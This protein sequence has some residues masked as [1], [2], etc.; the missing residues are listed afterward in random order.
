MTTQTA[1]ARLRKLLESLPAN[2][3]D[4]GHQFETIA[5]F[6]LLSSS[7]HGAQIDKIWRWSE[8]PG[9]HGTRDT[10]IDRVVRTK[11]G[12]LWAVQV[13]CVAESRAIRKEEVDSFLADS[14][15]GQFSQRLL[16]ATTDRLGVNAQNTIAKQTV[17]PVQFLGREWLEAIDI[18]WPTTYG[19]VLAELAAGSPSTLREKARR[20]PRPHQAEAVAD[21]VATLNANAGVEDRRASLVMA[22]GTGKTITC[23]EVAERM[24]ARSILVLLPNLTLVAQTMREWLKQYRGQ[25]RV[26]AVCGDVTVYGART[27]GRATYAEDPIL[28][29]A[30]HLPG[31]RL[32]DP[33]ALAN[34]LTEQS[35]TPSVVFST[36][37]SAPVV[38]AAQKLAGEHTFDLLVADEAHVLAGR[39]SGA[40]AVGLDNAQIRSR[41]R[42]FAT[43]TPRLV[44]AGD[45]PRVLS[46]DDEDTFGPVAHTLTFGKAIAAGL[47]ADYQVLV[48]GVETGAY[49][50]VHERAFVD[51]DGSPADAGS[52]AAVIAAVRASQEY[53]VSR[54]ISFHSS[55]KRARSFTEMVGRAKSWSKGELRTSLRAAWATGAMSAGE[56]RVRLEELSAA[57]SAAP[58]LL[59]NA[60]CLSTGID[61]PHLDAVIFADATKSKIGV[62]QAVGRAIRQADGKERG[63]II[64]PVPVERKA[65]P[66]A[67]VASSSF[68]ALWEV[69]A[70]LRDHDD[71]LAEELDALRFQLGATS[72]GHDSNPRVSKLLV[73]LPEWAG[74]DFAKAIHLRAVRQVASVFQVGLRELERFIE[75]NGHSRPV[76]THVTERGFALGF[77]TRNRRSEHRRGLLSTDKVAALAALPGWTWERREDPFWAYLEKLQEV[78]ASGHGIPAPRFVIDDVKLGNF[79]DR[80]RQSY[81]KGTLDAD[82][83][84]ALEAVAGWSWD[85]RAAAWE[86]A[87]A[88]LEQH[89]AETGAAR[90]ALGHKAANGFAI[91][92]WV[93]AQRVTRN[94]GKLS[95]GYAAR[96]EA[97]PGWSWAAAA[98]GTEVFIRA[99]E[100]YAEL[101]GHARIRNSFEVD[102]RFPEPGC[103]VGPWVNM[104]RTRYRAGTLAPDLVRRL[105]GIS[106]WSWEAADSWQGKCDALLEWVVKHG[107]L[108]AVSSQDKAEATLAR[109]TD[110]QRVAAAAGKLASAQLEAG[111]KVP[112]FDLSPIA[113][114]TLKAA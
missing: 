113:G 109:W 13:K 90:P 8:W 77:W 111:A 72:A 1:A 112:G 32:T 59:A 24:E 80:V 48:L 98:D 55:I 41:A 11:S 89:V 45:D 63:L 23:H 108:P 73:D 28:V 85:P 29:P 93:V 16:L 15:T 114:E 31:E 84:A 76:A 81:R 27:S 92:A 99:V 60:R 82:K 103:R 42:L 26:R 56:R 57:T 110:R 36:Y 64:V 12:E 75:Q 30:T 79:V 33:A 38:A 95:A 83:V 3:H 40:F 51:I 25:A 70:A 35:A 101:H 61:L 107:M 44:S 65:D 14:G 9:S 5:E 37:H 67:Q 6:A 46:M 94:K 53:G 54:A 17:P 96:L 66:N 47:L 21:I 58:R 102:E 52:V 43:A 2:N 78:V 87:F 20:A 86:A 69:L 7:T 10:G 4:R 104:Q 74:E 19:G 106:G 39:P 22:C 71:V 68:S 18:E 88:L 91:G 49:K 100:R 50:A 97:L 62:V 34:F 105:E